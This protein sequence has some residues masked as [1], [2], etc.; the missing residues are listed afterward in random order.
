MQ[1]T[2]DLFIDAKDSFSSIALADQAS[3]SR[4]LKDN[5]FVCINVKKKLGYYILCVLKSD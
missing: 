4:I 1:W 3:K 2:K 5:L